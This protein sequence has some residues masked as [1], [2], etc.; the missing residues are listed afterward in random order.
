MVSNLLFIWAGNGD[1]ASGTRSF[2]F[3]S[4]RSRVQFF[5]IGMSYELRYDFFSADLS[6]C[7]GFFNAGYWNFTMLGSDEDQNTGALP[8]R[9][10]P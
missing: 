8:A 6:L 2:S 1:F 4:L 10:L 5:Y 3:Q 7:I 9:K